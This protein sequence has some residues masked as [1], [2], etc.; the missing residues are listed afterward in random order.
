MGFT[1]ATQ[2][3]LYGAAK[4]DC[5][6]PEWPYVRRK[7]RD[8]KRVSPVRIHLPFQTVE[9]V[10]ESAQDRQLPAIAVPPG[11]PLC[12]SKL[13]LG[14]GPSPIMAVGKEGP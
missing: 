8:N 9:S 2:P 6:V 3:D 10:N 12:G 4:Q 13:T 1:R 7:Y 11:S 5:G 14:G